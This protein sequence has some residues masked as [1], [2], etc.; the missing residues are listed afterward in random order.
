[1]SV[2]V[3][4]RVS[5]EA[6]PVEQALDTLLQALNEVADPR[7]ARGIRH[8]LGATLA[9]CVLAFVCG[10][11]NLSGIWRF[12]R[13]HRG[14]LPGLGFKRPRSPSIP[15]LSR[16]LAAV[17]LL[18]LQRA[19]ARWLAVVI[20][21]SRHWGAIASVDG[22][23]SRAAGVHV[24]SVFLHD[25]QQVVWQTPVASK[26][27]EISAFKQALADLLE[28][29]PFLQLVVGDAMFAGEPLCELLIENGRHYLFQ[30]KADQP[31]LLEKLEL[32]FAPHLHRPL[33]QAALDGEK[34]RRLRRGPRG[35]GR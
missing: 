9:L 8:P 35:L 19:L 4:D 32:V 17:D 24:L 26:Q 6:P 3:V 27:N 1:M 5:E 2:A 29:Y 15:T 25:V 12:G 30:I 28:H 20:E 31:H 23:T 10:R 33:N 14:L 7:Q 22:K 16:L 13:Q 11:Q 34:K 18:D 21:R